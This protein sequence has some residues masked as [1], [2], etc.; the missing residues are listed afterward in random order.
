MC[1]EGEGI[2]ML[3][4]AALRAA[5]Y[6]LST[7][8]LRGADIRPPSVRG[9]KMICV[10]I[11][12][13][14]QLYLM[15]FTACLYRCLVFEIFGDGRTTKLAKTPVCSWVNVSA[16]QKHLALSVFQ[17]RGAMCTTMQGCARLMSR[18]GNL[19]QL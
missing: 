19:T 7:K 17:I 1:K 11:V 6:P 10:K 4:F 5:V 16:E 13:L 3:N 15:P 14:V 12:D 9:L 8:N 2:V 18:V